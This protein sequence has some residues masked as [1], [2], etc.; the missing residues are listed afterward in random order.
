MRTCR[1]RGIKRELT[2]HDSPQQNG[3]AERLNRTI[4]E[5]A[6]AMLISKNVPKFL[7]GEAVNY[8]TWLKNRLPS[9]AIPG[10]TPYDLING[11]RPDLSQAHEFGGKIFVHLPNAGKL[12]LRA[13]EAVFVGVDLESK[14]YRVYW[15][16]K[17]WVSVERNVSFVPTM[18]QVADD[19]LAEGE[20]D[21]PAGELPTSSH[22]QH[23]KPTTEA[24]KT[25]PQVAQSLPSP[26]TPRVT[27]VRPP[28]GYYRRLHE[29][30]RASVTTEID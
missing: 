22:V 21:V 18:V 5:L 14:A 12:E 10:H 3:V 29:G 1:K 4:V 28:T 2:V 30:E 7:W 16:G 24:P 9:H 19:I 11:R 26:P 8:A 23:V 17:R 27:R 15:P 25:P 6:R 13:E 20:L